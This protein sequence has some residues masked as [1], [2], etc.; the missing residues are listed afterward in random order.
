MITIFVFILAL[1]LLIYLLY[2]VFSSGI[3]LFINLSIIVLAA[4]RIA[5]DFKKKGMVGHY[6]TAAF[7]T[8]ILLV[9][10]D[11]LYVKPIFDFLTKAFIQPVATAMIFILFFANILKLIYV[12]GKQLLENYKEK[13][14]SNTRK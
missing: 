6:I 12:Q 2:M 9:A 13:S 10:K 1:L 8:V 7:L 11:T 5:T 14:A 3:S 4:G